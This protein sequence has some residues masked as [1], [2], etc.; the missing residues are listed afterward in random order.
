[1]N[2]VVKKDLTSIW[3]KCAKRRENCIEPYENSP[4]IDPPYIFHAHFDGKILGPE[5]TLDLK[6]DVRY[7]ITIEDE[8]SIVKQSIWEVL[9]EF[10]W[11]ID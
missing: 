9:T 6:P 4:K 3:F 1:M 5:E 11:K 8:D 2:T 7:R 10:S